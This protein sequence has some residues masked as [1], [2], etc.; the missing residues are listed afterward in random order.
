MSDKRI[1]EALQLGLNGLVVK[2]L[3]P[4]HLLTCVDAVLSGR[5]WIDHEVLHR[6]MD[7]SLS[8]DDADDPLARLSKRERAIVALLL[9]GM[10]NKEIAGELGIGEGTVKVHLHNSF[11]K[12]GVTSRTGLALLAARSA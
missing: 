4:Q 8:G 11:E 3:A 9:K 10:R 7:I 12:L 2:A 1:H 5:R 6:V